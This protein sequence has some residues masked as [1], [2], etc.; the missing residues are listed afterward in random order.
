VIEAD[1]IGRAFVPRPRADVAFVELE[2]EAVIA[3]ADAHGNV[4]THWLNPTGTIVWQ[5]FDGETSLDE[6]IGDL[7]EAFGAAPE[8]VADDIVELARALG[9]VGLLEDVA[10]QVSFG[11]TGDGFEPVG[12]P[13]GSEVP[14]F[15]RRELNGNEADLRDLRGKRVLLVNW[16][17]ACGFCASIAAEL[18][19]L[20]PELRAH[21]TRLVLVTFGTADDNRELLLRAGLTCT[22]LLQ[23]DDPVDVFRGLG[24]P[25]AYVLN[26]RG[27]VA[28]RLAVG[29]VQVPELARACA[30]RVG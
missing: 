13:Q 9:R 7:A 16:S 27:A 18:A 1:G 6:L 20:E 21:G 22:V 15:A 10:P 14:P 2:G 30:R 24:T 11:G 26:E 12:L 19:E 29:A 5:C 3:T 28:S 23:G 8:V 25:C 17:P 4:L